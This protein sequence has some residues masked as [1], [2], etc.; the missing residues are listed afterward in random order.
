MRLTKDGDKSLDGPGLS[1]QAGILAIINTIIPTACFVLCCL[2]FNDTSVNAAQAVV[3][4]EAQS[5]VHDIL[6]QVP[7]EIEIARGVLTSRNE[8]GQRRRIPFRH[9]IKSTPCGWTALY[10]TDSAPGVNAE[11]LEVVHR[12]GQPNQYLY[13]DRQSENELKIPPTVLQGDKASFSFAGTDFWL[14]DLGLEFLHWPEQHLVRDAKIK[15]RIGRSCKVLESVNPHQ[16]ESNYGRVV[17]WIDSEY[18][19]LIY[20]LAYDSRGS[21]AK[22]FSLKGFKKIN[23]VY[24]VKTMELSNRQT[25]TKTTLQFLFESDN[26]DE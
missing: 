23:D 18:G 7:P 20:A 16:S 1:F 17:S 14:A 11:R 26:E 22:V 12:T 8:D 4:L 10:E 2:S 5:L 24:H 13:A 3:D 21:L 19:G 6:A 25:H 15:M 9:S